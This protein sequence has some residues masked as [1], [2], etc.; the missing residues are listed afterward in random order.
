[1]APRPADSYNNLVVLLGLLALVA[2]VGVWFA[3]RQGWAFEFRLRANPPSR[4]GFLKW[5]GVLPLI[6]AGPLLFFGLIWFV[7]GLVAL[8]LAF[9]A[10]AAL[11]WR[12]FAREWPLTRV[13]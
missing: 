1:M 3:R 9:V 2:V 6:P 11:I 7:P 12:A 8:G 5:L 4:L 13:D 10:V